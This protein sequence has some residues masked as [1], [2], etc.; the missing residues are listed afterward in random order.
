MSGP[1]TPADAPVDDVHD[2]PAPPCIERHASR[3][4]D[5]AGMPVRRALP[6]RSRRTIG[7]W[8][9]VDH[10]GPADPDQPMQVG[11]HPHIGLQ[12]VTWLLSGEVLHHDS[13]GSEQLVR[14]GELNLMTAGHGIAHAEETPPGGTA[15]QHGVQLWVAQ[16]ESTRHGAPAFEHHGAL[17][18]V[19]DGAWVLTLLMGSA[20]GLTSP[21]RTDTALVGVALDTVAVATTTLPLE[22]AF[23]HGIVVLDGALRVGHETVRPG[24]LAYLGLGRDELPV[25]ADG[26][27]HAV[28]LGGEPFESELAMWWNFVGRDREELRVAR[29]DWADGSDRFGQVASRLARIDAPAW[30]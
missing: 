8:C 10:F 25:A 12:T 19:E 2:P 21:A 5:L 1:V 14:P 27:T 23:E 28:L 6:K 29:G 24:E 16:P 9:F 13:L 4:V 11:P 18:R 30:V 26:P 22:P 20:G 7:A 15:P 17:P 3:T